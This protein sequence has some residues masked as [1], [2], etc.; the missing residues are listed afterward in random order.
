MSA[1]RVD[2]KAEVSAAVCWRVG[3]VW[4][5]DSLE[6]DLGSQSCWHGVVVPIDLS[7]TGSGAPVKGTRGGSRDLFFSGI[8][9]LGRKGCWVFHG[10]FPTLVP[11]K[12]KL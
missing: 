2:Q 5:V 10:S 6:R 11:D 4:P 8:P 12:A 9:L 7:N 3:E 1:F